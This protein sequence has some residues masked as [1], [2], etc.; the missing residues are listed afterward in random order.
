MTYNLKLESAGT[1]ADVLYLE[2]ATCDTQVGGSDFIRSL[3]CAHGQ[4]CWWLW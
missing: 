2:R 3:L 4:R 1:A